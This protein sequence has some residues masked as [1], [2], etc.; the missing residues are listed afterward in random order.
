MKH[1]T[2]DKL[3]FK[4]LRRR[5]DI[6]ER[7]AVGILEL[8]WRATAKN[9]PQGDIGRF[10]NEEIATLCDWPGDADVLVGALVELRWFDV[11][12]ERRLLVHDWA[13]H[14]PNHVKGNAGKYD[15]PFFKP[16]SLGAH[17]GDSL[18]GSQGQSLG[19]LPSLT[20]PNHTKIPTE[21]CSEP[22]QPASE[23]SEKNAAT[24]AAECQPGHQG[25]KS[26]DA[27][28]PAAECQD[29]APVVVCI[30]PVVG[31]P[32]EWPLTEERV[33]AYQ[34]LFPDL[35]VVG[36]LRLARQWCLD[37]RT[38]RKTVSGMPRFCTNWLKNAQNRG[39]AGPRVASTSKEAKTAAAVASV[40]QQ[41]QRQQPKQ[42]PI[43]E[44]Q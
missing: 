32:T 4:K 34:R 26:L 16:V 38:K 33:A 42:L 5:L 2:P 6:S 11:C 7:E 21:S 8:L 17:I 12:D 24:A 22:A 15:R 44:E 39:E 28:D 40:R 3:K 1:D 27:A 35:D 9:C 20:I 23:P 25:T 19:A 18:G 10:S 37:N 29:D 14:C 13:E 43:L 30:F 41:L 31:K 36:Q